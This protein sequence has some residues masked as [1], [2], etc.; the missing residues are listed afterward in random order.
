[1]TEY[2]PLA[3]KYRTRSRE[4][5]KKWTPLPKI[6]LITAT[7]IALILI[8]AIS[9][10]FL[11]FSSRPD[12]I[13]G[14]SPTFVQLIAPKTISPDSAPVFRWNEVI[15]ADYYTFEFFD[16]TMKLM[17][18]EDLLEGNQFILPAEKLTSLAPGSTHYWRIT[19]VLENGERVESKLKELKLSR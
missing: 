4:K 12:S 17:W 6:R 10:Y 15:D 3:Q 1:M 5:P 7:A 19:A 16:D 13:R 14:V 9:G 8:T 2:E 18:T 11:I